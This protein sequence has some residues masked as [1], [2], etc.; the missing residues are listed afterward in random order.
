VNES[1]AILV[2]PDD[3]RGMADAAL[4]LLNNKERLQVMAAHARKTAEQ[5]A[6]EV[7][8]KKMQSLYQ[9]LFDHH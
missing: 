2:A 6:W 3:V 5:F 7:I 1:S 8:A 4:A 9:Q